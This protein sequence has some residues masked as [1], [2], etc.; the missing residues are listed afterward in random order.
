[1]YLNDVQYMK[2]YK[3]KVYLPRYEKAQSMYSIIFMNSPSFESS[4]NFMK[5]PMFLSNHKYLN[6][7]IDFN[8]I[9]KIGN[10]TIRNNDRK[11]R[12]ELYDKVQNEFKMFGTQIKFEQVKNRNAYFDLFKYNEIFFSNQR[13]TNIQQK[14]SAYIDMIKA[15][16]SDERFSSYKFKTL[17]I[18]VDAWS[19]KKDTINNPIMYLFLGYKRFFD[20]FKE[21]DIDIVFYTDNTIFKIN[22]SKCEENKFPTFKTFLSKLYKNVYLD[23]DE[24]IDKE[25]LTQDIKKQVSDDLLVDRFKFVGDDNKKL[26][27]IDN[28]ISDVIDD[29]VDRLTND[30]ISTDETI[31]DDELKDAVKVKLST[32]DE[33]IKTVASIKKEK[34]TGKSSQSIKRDEELRK[35]QRELKFKNSTIDDMLKIDPSSIKIEEND[36]SDKVV[37]TNPN[38]RKI[39]YSNFDNAYNDN[40]M[41]KDTLSIFTNLNDKSIPV[42]IV[43]IK[44]EDSSDE[45]N[46]KETYDITLEDDNRVR[47]KIKVDMPKFIDGKFLYLNGNKKIIVKQLTMKPIVKTGPDEVQICSNYN[48][49][50][51]RRYG[52]KISAKIEKLKKSLATT[53]LGITVKN[54]DNSVSNNKYK[55]TIEYDELAKSYMFIK[56]GKVEILFNQQEVESRLTTKL[57]PNEFCI[58]FNDGKPIIMDYDTEL[59]DGL[60]LVDYIVSVLGDSFKDVYDKMSAGGKRFV[61]TRATIMAKDIPIILLL[62]YCEGLTTVLKKANIK[63]RFSD[64]RVRVSDNEGII[65]FEDGYLI[66]DKYPFENS[67]LLNAL[68]ALPISSYSF[69]DFDDK[70]VYVELFDILFNARNLANAFDTFYEFMIDPITKSVLDDLDYP[71][72]FV[73]VVLFANS[74]LADNSYI[75]EN[76]MNLYRIRSNEIVNGILHKQITAAYAR[77]KSTANNKNPIKISIPRN[78]VIKELMTQINIEEL[79]TLNPIYEMEK[80]RAITPKGFVGMNLEQAY[81]QDKR[82][83]DKTMMGLLGMSTSP[84]ANVGVVRQLTMEPNIKNARGYIDIKDD[85]IENLT[86]ANLFTPAEMLTPMGVTRDDSIRTAMASKQSKHIIPISKAS[87]VLI[88]NGAE[89][90]IQYQL[91]KDFVVVAEDDGV[92]EEVD[93]KTGLVVVK[94]KNGKVQAIETNPKVVKNS[95]SGFYISNKLNCDL[96]P[97]QKVKK[98][99]ILASENKFFTTDSLN[100]NRFNIGSLQKVAVMS[101][102][103]TYEDSAFVTKKMSNDMAADI[104]MMKDVIIG[105]NANVDHIV[106]IGDSVQVGDALISFETSYKEAEMNKFLASVGDELKEE[107]QSLNKIPVKTKYAGVIE[108]IKMY[109][110]VDVEDLSPSL[111]KLLKEYYAGINRK[112]KILDKYDKSSSVVKAGILFNEPV[113]KIEPTADGKLKGKEVH[114]GV[115]IEFYVKYKDTVSVGDKITHFSALKSIVGEVIDEGYEPYSEYRPDEEISTFIGPS[116]ILQ[117]M[118]PSVILTMFG[119]KLLIELKRKLEE[120]YKI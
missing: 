104:I 2:L 111:Q 30:I 66:Y 58:G 41:A 89:Q 24:I 68:E 38:I 46:Y 47:H 91:S 31:S 45:L 84:D 57:K 94:Y 61:Y 34:I 29:K 67:L 72:D 74:L 55:T 25:I 54:G 63:Y 75:T 4:L 62:G 100:G 99:D 59:V 37:T 20:I 97:G 52:N 90:V 64:T 7:Y 115:L 39:K 18:D 96:K 98:N 101:S 79:S 53:V 40:L 112:K 103:S 27:D 28:D 60:E 13:Y 5:H 3:Q 77:Y 8:Y 56:R 105:K 120:I 87:P 85:D 109:S 80:V 102:Y 110:T 116:A 83:Y 50:F 17:V 21:L 35:K 119:N 32:D 95:A 51:L 23:D 88:S 71:T 65:K 43:D 70:E 48:K 73:S 9:E 113:G 117:R 81:T 108:D 44:V 26:D 118:T 86:D 76:N 49:I 16:I 22:P 93:D 106:K 82:S 15:K 33:L 42:H 19:K 36:V 69:S 107:I 11:G 6:Y 1:M 14:I 10:R 78:A 114:D 12:E 92:V